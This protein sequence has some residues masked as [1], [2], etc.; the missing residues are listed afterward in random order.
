MPEHYGRDPYATCYH[1][2]GNIYR[3]NQKTQVAQAPIG[4]E[5]TIL[6]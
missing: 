6:N 3:V 2:D 4:A 5:S 1:A